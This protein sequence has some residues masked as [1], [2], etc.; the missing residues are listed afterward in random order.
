[1]KKAVVLTIMS[2]VFCAALSAL[3]APSGYDTFLKRLKICSPYSYIYDYDGKKPLKRT[4][5]TLDSS[6]LA[7]SFNQEIKHGG[8]LKCQF[9][10]KDMKNVHNAFANG[11]QNQLFDDYIEQDVCVVENR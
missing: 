6:G 2:C 10:L 5:V 7:C 1:M 11:K 8:R 4:V 3:A 9:P